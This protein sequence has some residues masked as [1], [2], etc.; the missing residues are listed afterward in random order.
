MS[1]PAWDN[2]SDT[3]VAT[4][5]LGRVTPTASEVGQPRTDRFIGMFYFLW[6]TPDLGGP[7]DVTKIVAANPG[8]MENPESPPW[9]PMHAFHFWSEPLFG[10]YRSDDPWVLRK[11]AQQLSDAGVDVVI[12]DVTNQIT[13]PQS[14][15]ALCKAWSEVRAEGNQTPGI[16][17]LTP[18]W[19]PRNVVN[20]LW[21]DLYSKGLWKDLW[22][23]WKGKPLI[24]ADPAK[25]DPAHADFF[26]FRK[27]IPSY[28]T[29]PEGPDNWGWLEVYPQHVFPNSAGE[30][31]QMTVGAAQNAVGDRIGTLSMKN[32]RGRS[33]HSGTWATEPGAVNK[34][35]NFAEQAARALEV[36][37]QF[38]FVTGWNEWIAMR[39]NEFAGFR[40]PVMFVDTCDQEGSRDLEP[41]LGGHQDNYYY[42]FVDFARRYKGACPQP[43]A[44]PQVTIKLDSDF[45][46]WQAVT[47]FYRDNLGDV[48]HRDFP[49]IG[50]VGNYVNT[51]GR[52]D[53]VESKVAR[54]AANLYFW[55][56]TSEPLSPRS[57]SNWMALYLN[58]DGDPKTGWHGYDFV[59]NR[60]AVREG[61]TGLERCRGGWDWQ[62]LAE[63][64]L[65]VEGDQLMVSIPRKLLGLDTSKPLSLQFKWHDN[66][67]VEGDIMEF[68][69]SGD[70]APNDR[71][72]YLYWEEK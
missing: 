11:H 15:E 64:P 17:F 28:F 4:D 49:G 31:E 34:G 16:A 21:E 44:G 66:M 69:V 8:A 68:T 6:M 22:F 41:M 32:S 36:D 18:F 23:E 20:R 67:Q 40:E 51:T 63:V 70:A 14:Y 2:Y 45:A 5:D 29:G 25:V 47:D 59:V 50:S 62:P 60:R 1:A 71:F 12:F 48:K 7:Y 56:R 3:W 24:M 65:R 19:D 30:A 26:T 58:I 27:P 38:V 43:P 42:Q 37:P 33:F 9:G 54:D 13:Y 35:Y 46:Q 10:Y 53:I 61:T 72:N 52:N 55:A 39:F 57:D